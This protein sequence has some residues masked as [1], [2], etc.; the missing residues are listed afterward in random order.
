LSPLA[1]ELVRRLSLLAILVAGLMLLVPW[2]LGELGLTGP[3]IDEQLGSAE[4]ALNIARAYGGADD[5]PDFRAAS[6]ELQQARTAVQQGD[7]WRARQAARRAGE[8]AI[9]AQRSALTVRD[10]ARRRAATVA[11]EV[12]RRLGD[13]EDAYTQLARDQGSARAETLLPLMKEARR[14]GASVLLAIEEGDHRRALS[15]HEDAVATIERARQALEGRA[16]AVAERSKLS[17][18]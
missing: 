2:A 14:A 5:D 3:G 10:S 15:L 9:L 6:E 12:D 18:R 1:L 17:R 11:T 13:L 8:R 16:A 4:R 7:R